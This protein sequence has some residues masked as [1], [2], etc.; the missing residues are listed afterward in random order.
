MDREPLA[1]KSIET[2]FA[3]HGGLTQRAPSETAARTKF[4]HRQHL[5][6]ARV[7]VDPHLH[8]GFGLVRPIDLECVGQHHGRGVR[9]LVE[10]LEVQVRLGFSMRDRASAQLAK[11]G[12]Q[13]LQPF[14]VALVFTHQV[15][16]PM[17]W[18]KPGEQY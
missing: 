13:E 2:P 14:V 3:R 11:L 17:A 15:R 7:V 18:R 9:R 16:E 5:G 8:I 12:H 4:P 6:H 1:K 10:H